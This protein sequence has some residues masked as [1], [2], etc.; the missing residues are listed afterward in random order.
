MNHIKCYLLLLIPLLLL[1][2]ISATAQ[3]NQTKVTFQF[4]PG[5]SVYVISGKSRAQLNKEYLEKL[6][7]RKPSNSPA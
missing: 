2:A 6:T 5:Q 1:S 7:G 3:E 4:Q